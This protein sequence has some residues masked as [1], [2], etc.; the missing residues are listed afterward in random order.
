MRRDYNKRIENL[1]RR[2]FDDQLNKAILSESFYKTQYK[3]SVKYALE[4]MQPIDVAY[5]TNTFNASSKIKS[6]LHKE[7]YNIG[8]HSE[9]KYQGS[10]MMNT[11]IILHSDI[12]LLVFTKKYEVLENPQI[13]PNPYSGIP[14]DDL[15]ELRN[16]SF[17]ILN[18]IYKDVD[19]SK[20]KSI[21]VIP[22]NPKRKVDVVV[23]NWFNSNNFA[24]YGMGEDYRGVE[25]YNYHE[26]TK[27]AGFPFLH[28]AM[29]NQKGQ[30]VNNGLQKLIRLLK[31]LKV[32][33]ENKVELTS[34]EITSLLYDIP[35]TSLYK[36]DDQQ[37]LLLQEASKQLER[38]INQQWYRE[39]LKSP[40][41]SEYVFGNNSSKI[42]GLK[43]IKLELDELIQDVVDELRLHHREIDND[44]IYYSTP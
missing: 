5:N 17:K 8:L 32:D 31:T 16:A 18:K 26:H 24:V 23:C 34:F 36:R 7:L 25:I 10:A 6:H 21:Q 11:N 3:G 19:N 30:R 22:T 4:A 43:S 44:I 2:R 1:K 39:Q 38:L 15:R 12:D 13:P 29:V 40:N 28:I 33:A 41:Q 27:K 9:Y 37:L 42:T 14:L 20:S 35:E